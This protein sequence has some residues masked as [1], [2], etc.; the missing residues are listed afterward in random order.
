MIII[1]QLRLTELFGYPNIGQSPIPISICINWPRLSEICLSEQ[2]YSVPTSSDNRGC[3][4]QVSSLYE[5]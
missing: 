4:V 2:F 5:S 1:V 3:I